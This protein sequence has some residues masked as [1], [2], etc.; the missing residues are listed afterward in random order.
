MHTILLNSTTSTNSE[1]K[2]LCSEKVLEPFTTIV[3]EEQTEGRGQSGA[4]W[5]SETGKNLI[6]ST[7]LYPQNLHAEESFII[8]CIFSLSIKETLDE[9]ISDITIKWPNDIYY[10]DEKICGILIENE[11]SGE[12]ITRSIVGIGL[13]VNQ[14]I[15]K[16]DAPN[17][18]SMKQI[19]GINF[20]RDEL[21]NSILKKA[22]TLFE[23]YEEEGGENI[24]SDYK[25]ALYRKKGFHLYAD[26]QGYFKAK[27]EDVKEN[28]ILVLRTEKG[29]EKNYM[30]KEVRFI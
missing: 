2:N 24:R 19:T 10:K 4:S 14:E 3:T 23:Y 13:N 8:S 15:F 6:F 29:E 18:I 25:N 22:K 17:P 5:E 28:G 21:L 12:L 16:G 7:V 9:Y 11:I 30:F 1:L 26:Y 27:I 20:D